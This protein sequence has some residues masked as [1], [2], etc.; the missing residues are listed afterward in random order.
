MINMLIFCLKGLCPIKTSIT[1]VNTLLP[2]HSISFIR[3]PLMRF[4][5]YYSS[6][7][8]FN[9]IADEKIISEYF[10][11]EFTFSHDQERMVEMKLYVQSLIN[12][13]SCICQVRLDRGGCHHSGIVSNQLSIDCILQT[14]L[15]SHVI[16]SGWQK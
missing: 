16:G 10:A 4:S 11:D 5:R 12:T 9:E 14:N 15:L 13:N 2:M 7:A 8:L 3:V 6:F 1:T